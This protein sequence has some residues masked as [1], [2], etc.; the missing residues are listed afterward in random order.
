MVPPAMLVSNS[1]INW[2]GMQESGGRRV[3]KS[4]FLDLFSIKFCDDA[5]LDGIR[6]AIPLL[7][8]YKP[9]DGTAPTNSQVYR[10]YIERYLKSLPI[11]NTELD[12]IVSQLQVTTYGVPIQVYFFS[13][14]K[15]WR[16]YE[17]I[18]SDI[19]DHLLAIVGQFDLKLYQY[20]N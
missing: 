2:R 15:V 17:I 3:N 11:V 4:I 20:S 18:Q 8:D 16:E 5:M 13:R 12:L 9:E 6:K 19:F 14:D 10:V 7:A 1:F